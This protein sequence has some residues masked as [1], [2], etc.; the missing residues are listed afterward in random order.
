[1]DGSDRRL[2]SFSSRSSRMG[3]IS[4]CASG[5]TS[6]FSVIGRV[7]DTLERAM[8]AMTRHVVF[9]LRNVTFLDLAGLMTLLRANERSRDALFDVQ[10]IP[11]EGLASRVFTLRA[12]APS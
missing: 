12:Q 10:L 7:E 3:P 5:A 9:D 8:R 1:M 11:P 4:G 6:S 2:G